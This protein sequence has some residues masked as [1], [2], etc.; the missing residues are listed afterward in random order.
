MEITKV[1]K[2]NY[3]V[4]DVVERVFMKFKMF[5]EVREK[6]GMKV[7]RTCFN[8]NK[9]FMDDDDM[10]LAITTGGNKFLCGQ[11]YNIA[12]NDLKEKGD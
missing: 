3:R 10:F 4:L 2:K 9:K 11:C 8:C 1:I 6:C 5:K 7:P 12:L